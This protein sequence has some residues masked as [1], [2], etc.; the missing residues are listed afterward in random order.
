[1]GFSRKRR[2]SFPHNIYQVIVEG[3]EGEYAEYEIEADSHSEAAS[4]AESMATDSMIDI[5]NIQ[6]YLFS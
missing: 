4:L 5:Q 1:M 3:E 6:V 2:V